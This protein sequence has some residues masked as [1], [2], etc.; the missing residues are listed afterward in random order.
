[1]HIY[2]SI[3]LTIYLSTYL[4]IYLSTYLPIYLSTYLPIYLSTYLPIYLSIYLSIF[5]AYTS[6]AV[7]RHSCGIKEQRCIEFHLYVSVDAAALVDDGTCHGRWSSLQHGWRMSKIIQEASIKIYLA[8]NSRVW[9]ESDKLDSLNWK[10][11]LK[12]FEDLGWN[13]RNQPLKQ[14]KETRS[15]SVFLGTQLQFFLA[16]FW[17]V[18]G[19]S[20]RNSSYKGTSQTTKPT[21]E[22]HQNSCETQTQH[23]C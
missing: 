9:M 3:Y 5:K 6:P 20:F 19:K 17:E 21:C 14:A 18:L 22:N 16:A 1:M 15:D 23:K 7:F 8:Q 13:N 11:H 2:L 4:P 12:N 10:D